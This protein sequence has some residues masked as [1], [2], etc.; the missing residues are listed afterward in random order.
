VTGDAGPGPGVDATGR[1][2][3]DPTKNVETRVER[4]VVRLDDMASLRAQY[5]ER[6]MELRSEHTEELAAL[7]EAHWQAM[8]T[9][10]T[11]RLDAIRAVDAAQARE[12]ASAAEARAATLA[13]QV[14]DAAVAMRTQVDAARVAASESQAVALAPMQAAIESLRQSQYEAQGQRTQVVETRAGGASTGLWIGLA[15]AGFAAAVAFMAMVVAIIL[16]LT[17]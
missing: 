3:I 5:T 14:S 8:Q 11:E 16:T 1:A 9:K 6:I 17:M 2:V 10:E 12:I 15:I 4:E 13:G 7:R